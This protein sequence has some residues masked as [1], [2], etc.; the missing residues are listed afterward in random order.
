MELGEVI[1]LDRKFPLVR[2]DNDR[3]I[4]C[5]HAASLKKNQR[6]RA[7]IGDI[8]EVSI[9]DGHDVGVIDR[10]QDRKTSFVRKDPTDR[11]MPHILAA[12][13]DQVIIVQPANSI[14]L[15][16]LQRELVLAHETGA[17]VSIILTKADEADDDSLMRERCREVQALAGKGVKVLTM[18][19]EDE[20][21]VVEVRKLFEPSTTSILIGRSGVGKSS[22][23]NALAGAEILQTGDVRETDGK[24]R[25][26][27]VSR[28]IIELPAVDGNGGGRAV[29]MP[30]VRGLGLWDAD[31][32]IDA[33][34]ADIT[35]LGANCKFRDC[36]HT[37][38]PGC[39]VLKAVDSGDIDASR[40]ESYHEL[41]Q[42][43]DDMKRKRE[44][45]KWKNK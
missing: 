34:Y 25:H 14:Q 38:E 6:M 31:T 16:R 22:L 5:E 29:D 36:S 41:C 9:P 33:A 18:S 7:V 17:R 23:I 42:E 4:R 39:A 11:A 27:T 20:S 15:K 1:K 43:L 26:T 19:V 12:N 30:G 40:L 28:E 8:V 37:N 13:F 3:I 32:G 24:G 44:R 2:L 45:S 21:S 35:A 10:I